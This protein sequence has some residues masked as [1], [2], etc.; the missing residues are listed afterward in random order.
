MRKVYE[1]QDFKLQVFEFKNVY[2]VYVDNKLTFCA[3]NE[4]ELEGRL[5]HVFSNRVP[6]VSEPKV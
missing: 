3:M 2:M 4:K 5:K 1:N 6:T